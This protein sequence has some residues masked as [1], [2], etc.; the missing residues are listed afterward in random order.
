V[1]EHLL[2]KLEVLNSNHNPIKKKSQKGKHLKMSWKD[3]R[4]TEDELELGH[5]NDQDL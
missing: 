1:V 2:C 4:K 3:F 5:R